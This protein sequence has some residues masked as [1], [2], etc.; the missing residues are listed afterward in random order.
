MSGVH[1]VQRSARNA[2]EG[3]PYTIDAMSFE[4]LRAH[5]RETA[6]LSSINGLVEW[7]EQ[8][9]MPPA[10]ADWRA[11][12]QAYLAGVIHA[13]RTAPELGDWLAELRDSDLAKDPEGDV[14]CVVREMSRA[15]DRETKLPAD[16]VEE[17][18][19]VSSQAHHAWVAARKADDFKTFRPVLERML[20]LQRQR[21]EAFG[22]E[23]SPYDALLD[24]YEPGET[25]ASVGKAL[26]GEAMVARAF[27]AAALHTRAAESTALVAPTN[28]SS[29]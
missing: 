4:K 14:G 8:T 17:V 2:A 21:A 1:V 10:A 7:D 6:L 29:F 3:V 24:E 12:Q 27:M 13:R 5:A 23:A 20:G 28:F 22:Y 18:A 19:R 15:Y 25:G 11:E 9:H 16:L 26:A